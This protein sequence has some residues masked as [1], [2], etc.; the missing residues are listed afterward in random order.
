VLYVYTF[1]IFF[2]GTIIETYIEKKQHI[3]VK[4]D[5]ILGL[6]PHNEQKAEESIKEIGKWLKDGA[7]GV[8]SECIYE[9]I[10]IDL[11]R[12]YALMLLLD[13]KK[14]ANISTKI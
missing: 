9:S 1:L 12:K 8:N 14:I 10:P 6:Y 7:E 4:G 5:A 13:A 2:S 3:Y 11:S